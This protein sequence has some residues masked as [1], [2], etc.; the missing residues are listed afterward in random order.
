[1]FAMCPHTH[2]LSLVPKTFPRI[3]NN[4]N[5][6]LSE[7]WL[8]F[9]SFLSVILKIYVFRHGKTLS[10]DGCGNA[11]WKLETRWINEMVG[12]L[13]PGSQR[14][15]FRGRRSGKREGLVGGSSGEFGSLRRTALSSYERYCSGVFPTLEIKF[16]LIKPESDLAFQ[17]E[18]YSR[19]FLHMY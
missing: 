18:P 3:F 8:D 15:C 14:S 12:W 17:P 10:V 4:E 7:I 11:D 19:Y 16:S 9:P 2:T 5:L 1:M 6:L 13:E